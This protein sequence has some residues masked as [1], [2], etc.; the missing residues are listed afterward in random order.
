MSDALYLLDG[1]SLVYRSYFAFI[2]N[3]LFNPKGRNASAVFGFFRSLLLLLDDRSPSHFAVVLDSRTPT[4]RHEKYEEYKATREKTPED[5]KN[6]I[7]VIEEILGKLGVPMVR[8]DGYEADDVMATLALR[9]KDEGRSCFVVSGDKDLLQLVDGP[10]TILKPETGGGFTEVDRDGVVETWGVTPEQILD[11]LALVGDSSDNVPGVKGIGAKT[12][13]KLLADYPTLDEIYAHLDEIS[14]KSQR[15]KL[16]DG[17]DLAFLS[18]DLVRLETD[19]P[20]ERGI[21]DLRLGVLDREAAAPYFAAEGMRSLVKEMTGSESVDL[22]EDDPRMQRAA[23]VASREMES[24]LDD[25]SATLDPSGAADGQAREATRK[26]DAA[27]GGGA[28]AGGD[29][30]SGRPHAAGVGAGGAAAGVTTANTVERPALATRE[31]D[32]GDAEPGEYELVDTL[33]ALERWCETARAAGLVAFDCETTSLDALEARPVGFSLSAER[34]KACYVALHGPDG[35]VLPVDECRSRIGA[36]LEDPA[37]RVVGQ[38]LKYDYKVMARWGVR[39]ANAWFDTMI[40][41]WLLDTESN[42]LGMDAL[43]E[44]YLGY[45]TLHYAD[46]VPKAARGEPENAFDA[47]PLERATSYAAED[48]DVTLRLYR[49]LEPLLDE[50]GMTK[51]FRDIEMPLLPILAEMELEG[52]RLD[53]GELGRYSVELEAELADIEQEIYSLVGHEFNIGSTKQLQ[54]VLF[55]ERKLTP[56]KKTKTGYSTDVSVLQDLAREDPV[57][58]LVLRNRTLSKLKSTYVDSLPEMVNPETG[59]VH[60]HFNING[61]ATGR[62]SS[63]DPNLQNIPIRDEEGRRIRSAFV[64]REGWRFVSA[65]YSQ[66]EL[67]VLAHLSDDPGLKKAFAEGVDVH[68]H[69]GSLIFGVEPD[70][71]TAAQRRIA[72]TINFGVMYGMSAFRLARDLQIPRR[73]ADAFIEAYFTTYSRIRSFI[74]ETVARAEEQGYVETILGRRRYLANISN[75]NRTVKMASER[76]AVNT[77]IQG[78]AADIMKKAMIDLAAALHERSLESRMLLQVHDELIL[79]CPQAEVEEA[80]ALVGEVMANAVELSIPLKVSVETGSSWGEMH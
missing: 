35:P 16:A 58:A 36:L 29:G 30:G 68:R 7:P 4:F 51:L 56:G 50:R 26:A 14:S 27:G 12:A 15:Q 3:P 37:V 1:Y 71:V 34:G 45:G 54:Q 49:V 39:I 60:T 79:E 24:W 48:A 46:V 76:V 19:V 22:P 20:L 44:D 66:I 63:T 2:R 69:T 75:R 72:K 62:I 10:V 21:D 40:A 47:V 77:P 23:L 33:E 38:N 80:G 32:P 17:R 78:S 55:E 42:R 74:D 18:R 9:A 25:A 43:A 73:D 5:L 57:P 59:R 52:I 65:D 28:G 8:V 6:E 13:A 41:A 61:T 64:P 11:Y 70:D 67:V 53:T 31:R